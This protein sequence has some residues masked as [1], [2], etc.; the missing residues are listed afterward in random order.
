MYKSLFH[1]MKNVFLNFLLLV[2]KMNN[3]IKK[4]AHIKFSLNIL[5]YLTKFINSCFV[6][7]SN[8][9]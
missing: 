1:L 3:G 6:Y 8:L 2:V 9:N 7:K 4:V 5:S